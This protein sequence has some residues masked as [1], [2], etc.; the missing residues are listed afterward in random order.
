MVYGKRPREGGAV[1]LDGAMGPTDVPRPAAR[2]RAGGL[3][4]GGLAT[5]FF[6][7]V[8]IGLL[9]VPAGAGPA[10]RGLPATV[11]C[12]PKNP[13]PSAIDIPG[14]APPKGAAGDVLNVSME[15]LVTNYTKVDHG[16]PLYFPSLTAVFPIVPTGSVKLFLSA[17][18]VNVQNALWSNASLFAGSTTLASGAT[19]KQNGSAYLT[20]SKIAVMAGLP[21]G[22]L[23]LKVRWHWT[24]FHA[25]TGIHA[26]GNWTVPSYAAKSPFL[27]SIFFPASY[28]GIFAMSPNPAPSNSTYVIG[29]DGAVTNT[30]FRMVLE[31]PNN[32]T[33]IQSIYE[34]TPANA[35][36][37]NATLPMAYRNG[38]GVPGG[39]YLMHVHDS[40][41]AIVHSIPVTVS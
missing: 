30:W 33:E 9:A 24:I 19:F 31:Y 35:T 5:S 26:Q 23:A 20:T 36:Q 12:N 3:V 11:T 34:Y 21:T 38:T 22:S 16:V 1:T 7:L 17:K 15:F 39:H 32:G 14:S 27:P 29:L 37:Y 4:R 40:C 25:R 2:P 28:V 8:A 6:A 41:Q 18:T 10:F 13:S